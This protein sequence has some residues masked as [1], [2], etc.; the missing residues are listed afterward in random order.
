MSITNTIEILFRFIGASRLSSSH[1]GPYQGGE[2]KMMM[3]MMIM[4][5]AMMMMISHETNV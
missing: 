5:M 1:A 2:M 4:M 3:M